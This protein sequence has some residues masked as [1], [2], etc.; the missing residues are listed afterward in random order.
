MDAF[1]SRPD[2]YSLAWAEEMRPRLMPAHELPAVTL[3]DIIAEFP[4]NPLVRQFLTA[5]EEF[6]VE[7][8]AAHIVTH[9]N[10]VEHECVEEQNE[11]PGEEKRVVS[12]IRGATLG[13]SPVKLKRIGWA[14]LNAGFEP[15]TSFRYYVN[16]MKGV[17]GS[18]AIGWALVVH[19]GDREAAKA[20]L[21]SQAESVA[22]S[23]ADIAQRKAL[24]AWAIENN[25]THERFQQRKVVASHRRI[26][27]EVTEANS[28]AA[29]RIVSALPALRFVSNAKRKTFREDSLVVIGHILE[30]MMA[31][32]RES[33]GG[34][35]PASDRTLS[36][37]ISR[38][39]PES[40]TN[41]MTVSRQMAWITKGY[42]E[43]LIEALEVVEKPA[44]ITEPTVYRLGPGL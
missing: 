10:G 34:L 12:G 3:A 35:I 26:S 17:K 1:V 44:K 22:G 30:L 2:D 33:P 19:D 28:L 27:G 4:R 32:A 39:W 36:A 14:I 6:D 23:E 37:E 5:C 24:I 20:W 16:V 18:N 15:G 25:D 21:N 40:A 9:T 42:G 31:A 7:G 38:R 11:A 13:A 29:Q 8:H 41:A 43:C